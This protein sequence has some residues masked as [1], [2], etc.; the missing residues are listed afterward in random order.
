MR[1]GE[2][3]LTAAV[4]PVVGMLIDHTTVD[5][6]LIVAGLALAWFLGTV[7]IAHSTQTTEHLFSRS[8][9][10]GIAGN[11]AKDAAWNGTEHRKAES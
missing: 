9:L 8:V 2:G 11:H 5:V 4:I 3:I 1:T 6:A 10:V 7:M